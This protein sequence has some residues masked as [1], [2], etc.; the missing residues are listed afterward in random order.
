MLGQQASA[1]I[2]MNLICS[3]CGP[4]TRG[5]GVCLA[6]PGEAR[7]GIRHIVGLECSNLE[8]EYVLGLVEDFE[9][10]GALLLKGQAPLRWLRQGAHRM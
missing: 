4:K 5:A 7:N 6:V 1:L 10:L 3:T 8:H 9:Q 2:I